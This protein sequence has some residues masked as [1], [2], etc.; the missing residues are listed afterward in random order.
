[1]TVAVS[2]AM[3]LS[4]I[5]NVDLSESGVFLDKPALAIHDC[6]IDFD[7]NS[8]FAEDLKSFNSSFLHM[9]FLTGVDK[10]KCSCFANDVD[11]SE[12][13]VFKVCF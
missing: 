1:M 11:N 8:V 2:E 13:T 5:A 3:K 4:W 7:L 6:L 12:G 9:I 10:I